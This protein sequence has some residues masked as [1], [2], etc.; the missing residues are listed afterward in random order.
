MVTRYKVSIYYPNGLRSNVA[1]FETKR[2]A[3]IYIEYAKRQGLRCELLPI[4][5]FTVYT[6]RR[7]GVK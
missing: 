2:A 5:D 1:A 3:D 4:R 7:K 6:P